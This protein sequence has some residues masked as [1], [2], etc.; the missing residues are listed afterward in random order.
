MDLDDLRRD[1]FA[2]RIGEVFEHEFADGPALRLV[3]EEV[4]DL[5]TGPSAEGDGR[6]FSL[7]FTGLASQPLEQGL[8]TLHNEGLG[9]LLVFLVPIDEDEERR[10]YEAIFN[11]LPS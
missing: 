6:S 9:D 3:L 11:R 4:R 7:L 5:P 10:H 1:V 8:V 2:G